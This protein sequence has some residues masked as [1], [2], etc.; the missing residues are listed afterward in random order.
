MLR[1]MVPTMARVAKEVRVDAL[2]EALQRATDPAEVKQLQW[3]LDLAV[4]AA[5]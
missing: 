3:A 1:G 4:K 2:S 5:V